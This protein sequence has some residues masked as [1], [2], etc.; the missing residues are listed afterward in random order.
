MKRYRHLTF[1]QHECFLEVRVPRVRLSDGRVAQV[2]PAFAGT[3]LGFTVLFEAPIPALCREMPFR[4]VSRLAGVSL[5]RV[6]SLCEQYVDLAVAQQD[7]CGV[8]GLAIDETSRACGHDYV[9]PAADTARRAV[10]AV[11][12][13]RD[14]KTIERLAQDI[15]SHGGD[16]GAIESVSIDMSSA[17]IKGVAAH[18]PNTRVAFDTFH[19]IAHALHALD[20]TRRAEQK[21]DPGLKGM[22]WA[23]LKDSR[24]LTAAA[25][26]DLDVPMA[27]VATERTAR[28][29][30]DRERLREILNRKQVNIVRT[31][32]TQWRTNLT[33]SKV[34]PMKEGARLIRR[35]LEG[36]INWAKTRATNG[37]L[38]ALNGLFQAA[39]RKAR[40]Y[41]RFS[42]IRTV[43]FRIAGK[44]DFSKINPHMAGQPT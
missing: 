22:R 34:G 23:R 35:H 27:E 40:A 15:R 5:H 25:R 19:V 37:F 21:A 38:E 6:M 26:E 31:L 24:H 14:A 13:E 3:L 4:A 2:E 17:F 30:M 29:W 8:R 12:E 28:A 33:R 39:K 11:P 42:T 9:T 32:L 10:I 41:G 16:P 18:R 43:I 44:R 36:I 1:F 20:L 7:L